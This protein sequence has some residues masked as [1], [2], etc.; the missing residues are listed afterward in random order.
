MNDFLVEVGRIAKALA[1]RDKDR[2]F[3]IV[4]VVDKDF[5]L[6]ADGETRKLEKPK[7][8]KLKHLHLTPTV[9]SVIAEK[10]AEEKKVFD[11]ELRSAIMKAGY[12]LTHDERSI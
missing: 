11:A 5:V 7:L 2:F 1:G 4:K 12:N 10:I 6:L 9:L 8:K 3:M